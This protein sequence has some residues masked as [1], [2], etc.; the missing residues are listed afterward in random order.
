MRACVRGS[1]C[2]NPGKPLRKPGKPLR[3]PGETTE[4]TRETTEETGE[5]T[6]EPIEKSK[7]DTKG[8]RELLVMSAAKEKEN[9]SWN[10]EESDREARSDGK[11]D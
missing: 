7:C 8:R 1:H 4:E 10:T 9:Q 11:S 2:E 5:T 6:R 3:K